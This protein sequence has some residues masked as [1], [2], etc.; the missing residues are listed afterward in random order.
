MTKKQREAKKRVLYQLVWAQKAMNIL[1][2]QVDAPFDTLK[3]ARE[4]KRKLTKEVSKSSSWPR[5]YAK[6]FRIRKVTYEI[7]S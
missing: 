7:V 6:G 1:G 5:Q 2:A 3:E 4:A